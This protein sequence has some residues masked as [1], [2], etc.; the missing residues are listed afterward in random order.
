MYAAIPVSSGDTTGWKELPIEP[1]HEPLVALGTGT[2]GSIGVHPTYYNDDIEGALPE[3][4]VRRGVADRLLVAQQSLPS[5]FQL[6]VVD[7]FRSLT[8]QKALYERMYGGLARD[9]T[10]TRPI[11]AYV[12][13]PSDDPDR[14]SPHMT[15]GAVDVRICYGQQE[16]HWGSL[17]DEMTEVSHLAYYEDSSH[18]R[19]DKDRLARDNRR[20]LFFV[21][22]ESG[23][24]P[25]AP[26][27]WHF[28]A[29]QSQMG[30]VTAG[31]STASYGL[32]TLV[33]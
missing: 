10:R 9:T 21:M 27:W 24:Q 16:L 6:V 7:G 28:N 20:M 5:G 23:M 31:L 17:H 4:Y 14:P 19:T 3:L 22:K 29:P 15:G 33:G 11:E 26:E 30:A 8:I 1:S 18:L 12:S 25:Y 13:L 32:A 2:Y